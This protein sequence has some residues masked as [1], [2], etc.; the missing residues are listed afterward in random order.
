VTEYDRRIISERKLAANR[1]NALKSTGPR[2][3]EGKA[4][5][6][7]NALKHGL[8]SGAML[9]VAPVSRTE[10]DT[11]RFVMAQLVHSFEPRTTFEHLLLERLGL[12]FLRVLRAS[13]VEAGAIQ[14][15]FE[16]TAQQHPQTLPDHFRPILAYDAAAER[17]ILRS[18]RELRLLRNNLRTSPQGEPRRSQ[19]EL[20]SK[21]VLRDLRE[22]TSPFPPAPSPSRADA[23]GTPNSWDSNPPPDELS[24]EW[25]AHLR[26]TSP[27]P[28]EPLPDTP[29]G[30]VDI[31]SGSG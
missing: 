13:Y 23:R 21:A 22:F 6:S 26:G 30:F 16:N 12:A 5:S 7:R 9:A 29:S 17:T 8:Y 18:L 19:P 27:W 1:A 20:P 25:E 4:R 2:T 14:R 11:F 15:L 10:R 31:S 3:P 28:D 24:A